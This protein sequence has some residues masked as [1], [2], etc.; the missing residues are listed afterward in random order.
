MAR[1]L[2]S[3]VICTRNRADALDQCFDAV[4]A[5]AAPFSWELIVVDNGSQDGTRQLVERAGTR[6]EFPIRYVFEAIPGLS[7]A[8]NR[9]IGAASG[10]LIVFTDDDC[11]PE[12]DFLVRAAEAFADPKISFFGGRVLLHDP[13]DFPITVQT[14]AERR[15]LPPR[16][17]ISPGLIHG[18]NMGFRRDLFEAIGGFDESL[19]AGT[20]LSCGEDT[21]FIGRASAA[22]HWGGYFP[23]P[24]VH[25][26][27]GR[28]AGDASAL[29]RGY[30][31]GRGAYYAAMLLRPG[32]RTRYAGR[33]LR[34]M[35][36]KRRAAAARELLGA[37]RFT[38][39]LAANRLRGV[40]TVPRFA[41]AA[42]SAS[43][44]P[45]RAR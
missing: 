22:G 5:L 27:H 19:G 32:C 29:M 25:H 37:T 11:Y 2:I 8:R 9:G 42:G 24:T 34:S 23:E 20:P 6:A 45:A 35:S 39:T 36:W 44:H 7:R 1:D 3:L 4:R 18:A 26:H 43:A 17:F 28:K 15:S 16:S 13:E 10:E 12:R 21:E 31:L 30:D 41:P 33:W 40:S 14:S 38:L